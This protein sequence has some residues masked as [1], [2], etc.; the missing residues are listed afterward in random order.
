MSS[1]YNRSYKWQ[2][3]FTNPDDDDTMVG[4][5]NES[6]ISK[7]N[8]CAD[9]DDLMSE[10]IWLFS[11]DEFQPQKS[12]TFEYN[13]TKKQLTASQPNKTKGRSVDAEGEF[14][15]CVFFGST[16]QSLIL[17]NY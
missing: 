2:L 1:N 6:S 9:T 3:K 10:G 8:F 12:I 16:N 5:C 7:L 13:P 17:I 14:K 15:P 4:I 11:F